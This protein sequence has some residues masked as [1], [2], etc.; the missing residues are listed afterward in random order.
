[1]MKD[2]NK[3]R[4]EEKKMKG[5]EEQVVGLE[6]I[7]KE[8]MNDLKKLADGKK[9]IVKHLGWFAIDIITGYKRYGYIYSSK[10]NGWVFYMEVNLSYQRRF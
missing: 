6:L 9:L 3:N 8:D 7:S 1:M 10:K 2:K 4:K 5:R